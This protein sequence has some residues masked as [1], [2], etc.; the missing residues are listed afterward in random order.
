MSQQRDLPESMTWCTIGIVES[1]GN[2]TKCSVRCWSHKKCQCKTV[3][4]ISRC[5][6][7]YTSTST[8]PFMCYHRKR[9]PTYPF[10]SSW[11]RNVQW[12]ISHL[13]LT[14][15]RKVT[16][17]NSVKQSEIDFINVFFM[18]VSQWF[19]LR[20]SQASGWHKEDCQLNIEL[21]GSVVR[22]KLCIQTR[23]D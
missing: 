15:G 4:L 10:N 6:E 11:R 12:Y 13:F 9:W 8:R 17:T 3:E 16:L 14:P 18:H 7:W 20:W 23:P 19:V 2:T 1:V 22:I 5:M 21:G